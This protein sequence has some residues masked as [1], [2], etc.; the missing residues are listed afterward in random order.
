M[1]VLRVRLRV[2]VWRLVAPSA[3]IVL[4]SVSF[5]ATAR[6]LDSQALAA[7]PYGC[8]ASDSVQAVWACVIG[9]RIIG[10]RPC[11]TLGAALSQRFPFRPNFFRFSSECFGFTSRLLSVVHFYLAVDLQSAHK[12][13]APAACP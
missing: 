13:E 5:Y 6:I 10:R 11:F 9:L 3:H 4:L 12:V 2:V 8:D 7:P 1:V